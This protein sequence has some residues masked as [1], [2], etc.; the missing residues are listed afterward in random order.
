MNIEL[1]QF[2]AKFKH[3][4]ESIWVSNRATVAQQ[5]KIATNKNPYKKLWVGYGRWKGKSIGKILVFKISHHCILH[6]IR[7][8]VQFREVV[9]FHIIR[10]TMENGPAVGC[11]RIWDNYLI[12]TKHVIFQQRGKCPYQQWKATWKKGKPWSIWI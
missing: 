1:N 3:W 10:F 2:W 9:V 11:Q 4:I 12:L 7:F 5:Y 6:F 8:L